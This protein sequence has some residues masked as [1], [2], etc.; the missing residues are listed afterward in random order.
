MLGNQPSGSSALM[1]PSLNQFI[2]IPGT[3]GKNSIRPRAGTTRLSIQTARNQAKEFSRTR[4]RALLRIQPGHE[5]QHGPFM[6]S[7]WDTQKLKIP[8]CSRRRKK[9]AATLSITCLKTVYPGTILLTKAF[10]F[11]IA[12]HRPQRSWLVGY[13]VSRNRRR[14]R[15]GRLAIDVKANG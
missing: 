1:V 14:I 7:R 8:D 9:L 5:A 4:T 12:T 2:T 11:V 3:I 6:V 10:T 15:R 13:C